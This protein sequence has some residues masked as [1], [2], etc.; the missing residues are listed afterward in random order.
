MSIT[1]SEV[2]APEPRRTGDGAVVLDG[3]RREMSEAADQIGVALWPGHPLARNERVAL[4]ELADEPFVFPSAT[5]TPS[6]F[7]T[8]MARCRMAGFAPRIV[9]EASEIQT[10]IGLVQGGVGVALIPSLAARNAWQ[11]IAFRPLSDAAEL[12][13]TGL[14]L[15]HS[16]DR[17]CLAAQ[18]FRRVALEVAGVDPSQS[19]LSDSA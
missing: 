2:D 12:L 13:A 1:T 19:D 8:N 17:I 3:E 9:Q 10:T 5:L 18:H 7:S 11:R 16:P 4:A 15:V 14:A 6:L